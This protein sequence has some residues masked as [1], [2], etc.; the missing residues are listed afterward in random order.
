[1]AV[2]VRVLGPVEIALS[3]RRLDLARRQQRLILGILA[4][5]ANEPVTSTQMID[6]LWAS[7]P[8]RRARAVLQTRVSE[9]RA[10]LV[11]HLAGEPKV[12]LVSHRD[13]YELRIPPTDVDAG[14]FRQAVAECRKGIP[15]EAVSGKLR[16]A[17]SLWRG[18]V[19]GGGGTPAVY[20]ALC[21]GLESA[22][23]TAAEDLYEAELRLGRHAEIIEEVLELAAGNP[24]RERLV[25]SALLALSRARRP[26]EA[27]RRY[28]RWRRW[29]ASEL[30]I[31]P[32]HEV[33]E[34]YLSILRGTAATSGSPPRVAKVPDGDPTFQ[35]A[36][37]RTLPRDVTDFTGRADEVKRLRDLLAQPVDDRPPIVA[38]SGA[39]GVGKTAL[40]L[41]VAHE[42]RQRFP[43]G[44]LYVDLRGTR[45]SEAADP[46][47]VLG[48]LLRA[49][50]VDGSAVP[51]APEERGDLYRDLLAVR[52]VLIVLDDAA[53]TA[54]IL[55]LL[56]GGPDCAVVVS[57]R[58]RLGAELAV[59]MVNLDVLSTAE[60][61]ALLAVVAGP[62]RVA[63][64]PD[65]AELLCAQCGNLPL[66]IRIA[67]AKLAVKPHW[68]LRRMVDLFRDE[69][70]RLGHLAHGSLDVRESIRL[71]YTAMDEP[72]RRLFR[73]LGALGLPQATVWLSAALLDTAPA[74]AEECLDQLFD[75]RLVECAGRDRARSPA[76]QM[77]DL[78][79]LYARDRAV[80][81][82][83]AEAL[84]GAYDR[85]ID[86]WL[87]VVTEARRAIHGP[88]PLLPP[89]S[90]VDDRHLLE[91]LARPQQWL[92]E[93]LPS[94]CAA[95]EFGARHDNL[96]VCDLVLSAFPLLDMGRYFD[97]SLRA[98][99]VCLATA[100]R[101]GDH[102]RQALMLLCRGCVLT[103]RGDYGGATHIFDRAD[104]L[105]E[106]VD[107]PHGR[108]ALGTRQALLSRLKG[109]EDAALSRYH[110]A[111]PVLAT[112]DDHMRQTA[113][114]RG[115]GQ[116]HLKRGAYARAEAYLG[117][118]LLAS[119][120]AGA[121]LTEAQV[122]LW[123]SMLA[124]EQQDDREA[125]K[126][127]R[128]TLDVCRQ[129]GDIAGQAYSLRGLGLCHGRRGDI[130][131]AKGF[132]YDALAIAQQPR[133]TLLEGVI[134]R[135]IDE[136]LRM[137]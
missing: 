33:Q 67:G 13:G 10:A 128:T 8:P 97:E 25:A 30:G 37:P 48:R 114:L 134:R 18:P 74:D 124:M 22:R 92:E 119:R 75:A 9:L 17:L 62:E 137:S 2:S 83:P 76:Y 40:A 89:P 104:K 57:S 34:V 91:L 41:H 16:R 123:R 73:R 6:F 135:S 64:E 7:T 45:A 53:S 98:L 80:L 93:E 1:M 82:E 61:V 72:V 28:D 52:K 79:R 105:F 12:E 101:A 88:E 90:T 117:R 122:V 111:L 56:P 70:E 94:L 58:A 112:H 42:L 86:A 71:S 110:R 59:H 127:F 49:L 50:G 69:H 133:P 60:A 55:P 46:F 109:D 85:A 47:D 131:S 107:D 14:K 118:A 35:P 29:I 68:S 77:H 24:T 108:A 87:A 81:D 132:L 95:V 126:G 106:A 11:P 51:G 136:I 36:T 113:V 54:Q 129:F 130:A 43:D 15:D 103:D 96:A 3:E 65:A 31:D 120:R 63:A 115:I 27:V 4:L 44:Q 5:A 78:V 26:A 102:R 19:L 38:I 121:L 20:S 116:I 84:A 125:E 99:D 23:L 66:A 39:A 100:A 32:G 21:E